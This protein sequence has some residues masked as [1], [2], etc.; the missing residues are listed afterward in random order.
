VQPVADGEFGADGDSTKTKGLFGL[1]VD[2]CG[3]SGY[4]VEVQVYVFREFS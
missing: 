1:C 2:A 3:E 4:D